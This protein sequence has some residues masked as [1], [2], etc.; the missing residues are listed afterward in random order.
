MDEVDAILSQNYNPNKVFEGIKD[1]VDDED[2][3]PQVYS[4][5]DENG[6]DQVDASLNF[7]LPQN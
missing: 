6:D 2:I 4:W 3:E 7:M 1:D 5:T